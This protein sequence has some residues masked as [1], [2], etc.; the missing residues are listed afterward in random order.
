MARAGGVSILPLLPRQAM[1]ILIF[2]LC[3][4]QS[5]D[6]LYVSISIVFPA[7]NHISFQPIPGYNFALLLLDYSCSQ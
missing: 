6:I 5:L 2:N 7:L 3:Q 4:R 1:L